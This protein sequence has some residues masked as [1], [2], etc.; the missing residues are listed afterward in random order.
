MAVH[1]GPAGNSDLFYKQGYKSSLEVPA[2]LHSLGLDAYEYQC[3]RGIKI[4]ENLA[5]KL[6]DAARAYGIFLSIHAPYYI[7]LA[8]F[9]SE[10]LEKS[11]GHLLK[12]M[13][14]ACWMGAKVVVFHP[15]SRVTG[16]SS[17]IL[18]QAG[19]VLVEV[20]AQAEKEGLEEIKL[21]PET[22][23]KKGYLGSLEEVLHLC[24]LDFRLVP[25]IDFGHLHAVTGGGFTSKE[26]YASV[27]ETIRTSLGEAV[28]ENLHIHFSPVEFTPGG[29]KKH[30]T[31]L[32]NQFGPD[33]GPLA[34]LLAELK[35]NATVICESN[36]RQ[37]EDALIY[38][39]IYRQ[40]A[41]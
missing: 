2:W 34:E 15:G 41:T 17:E 1:F 32:E 40:K 9:S 5:K 21:A 11:K 12:S 37:V 20:L 14:V 7:N 10:I 19:E 26:D 18:S 22:M 27:L 30:W 16:K 8:S 25:A 23:G 39:S 3:T 35:L 6:G 24:S 4:G 31:T 33:F 38:Q 29:E 28:L 36:G 13:Q